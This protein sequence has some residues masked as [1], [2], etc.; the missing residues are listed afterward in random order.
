MATAGP[1]GEGEA[2]SG[3][4]RPGPARDG[5][6][7]ALCARRP[8]G[9]RVHRAGAVRV[10]QEPA[11]VAQGVRAQ[12][13]VERR[14]VQRGHAARHRRPHRLVSGTGGR[15]AAG[16]PSRGRPHAGLSRAGALVAAVVPFVTH[17]PTGAAPA[18]LKKE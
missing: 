6:G 8:T 14:E 7:A 15:Q 13:G 2:W 18:C 4:V 9:G 10:R 5:A 11:V 1:G 17:G 16:G 12:L 3:P